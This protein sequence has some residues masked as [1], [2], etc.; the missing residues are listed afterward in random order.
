[1][2]DV[3]RSVQILQSPLNAAVTVDTILDQIDH[4][5]LVGP[6]NSFHRSTLYELTYVSVMLDI[7]ECTRGTDNC[8]HR[9]TN[10]L[11][12]FRCSC[13]AGY[14]LASNG[15]SCNGKPT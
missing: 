9:C 12:S 11:G 13:N 6:H 3:A 4:P 14:R 1:M 10:T 8:A 2:E 7:N 15:V 5:V